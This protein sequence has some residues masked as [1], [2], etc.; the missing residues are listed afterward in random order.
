MS[1]KIIKAIADKTRF[2]LLKRISQGEICACN[3]PGYVGTSQPAVSQHLKVL[4]D[5]GLVTM[6]KNGVKRLY[7]ISEKGKGILADISR[8]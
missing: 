4:L 2:K 5:A 6:R 7:S 3:L 1:A 8:W